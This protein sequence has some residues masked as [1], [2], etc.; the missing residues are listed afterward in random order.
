VERNGSGC[1]KKLIEE[2]EGR[3]DSRKR[4]AGG[5]EMGLMQQNSIEKE[6]VPVV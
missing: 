3:D 6:T 4:R 2:R 5:N 1:E